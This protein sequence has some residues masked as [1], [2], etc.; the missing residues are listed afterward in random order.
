MQ[1]GPILNIYIFEFLAFS[2][3]GFV[4]PFLYTLPTH[5]VAHAGKG[6]G[7][8]VG[9]VELL[10][11]LALCAAD[12]VGEDLLEVGEG[13]EA[14][15]VVFHHSIGGPVLGQG[16]VGGVDGGRVGHDE[17]GDPPL[18]HLPTH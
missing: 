12:D 11:G 15:A 8:V 14:A 16:R 10:H 1:S 13:V 5:F 4:A 17:D 9:L 7:V 3:K 18:L 2:L 6:E